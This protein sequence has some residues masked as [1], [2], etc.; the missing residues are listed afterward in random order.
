[1]AGADST[2]TSS[3]SSSAAATAAKAAADG[4]VLRLS[5]SVGYPEEYRLLELTPEIL[6]QLEGSEDKM[7]DECSG[8]GG[9]A[10]QWLVIR[11]RDTDVATLVDTE[12]GA[13]RMATAHTSNNLY[14]FSREEASSSTAG[15]DLL[16]RAA[17]NQTFELQKTQPQIRSRVVEVLGWDRRGAFRGA[18]FE[19][20]PPEQEE[21]DGAA[22]PRGHCCVT[23]ELLKGHVQ[24][25]DSVLDRVLG[26]IPAFRE[27]GSR[28]W[29]V[30]DAGYCMDLLR[31]VLAT[32]V[33]REWSLD[34][35]DANEVHEALR[36]DT[37]EED[38]EPAVYK[39]VVEAVLG[40]FGRRLDPHGQP[41]VYAI[42]STRVAKYLAEQIFA[43]EDMRAWPVGEFLAALRA[44]MPPQLHGDIVAAAG[45]GEKWGSAAIPTSVVRDLAYATTPLDPQLVHSGAGGASHHLTYV[46]PLFRSTLPSDPRARMQ[47]LF[48]AKPRW[49]RLEIHPY[50]EDLVDV[51]HR[52]LEA[53][54]ARTLEAVN[55]AIDAWLLKFGRGVKSPGGQM[56]YSSRLK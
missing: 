46:V 14:L 16:L 21:V 7:S 22:A 25:G 11:G 10:E 51:D 19:Q 8:G 4:D 17:L 24:A 43:A 33:E 37:A 26:E 9:S 3:S 5:A 20:Q 23:D 27:P 47:R 1:M 12:D 38:G 40:R 44:T 42:D 30:L 6:A 2:T 48:D 41:S 29:R 28:G 31:L 45:D 13:Y 55:K 49:S 18:E 52:A 35:L 54:D 34:A 50:L 53:G 39:E 32:Q 36:S 15:G 56:V